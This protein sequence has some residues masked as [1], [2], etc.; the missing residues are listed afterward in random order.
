MEEENIKDPC[1]FWKSIRTSCKL[2]IKKGK[3]FANPPPPQI[4]KLVSIFHKNPLYVSKLKKKKNSSKKLKHS[5][6]LT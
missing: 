3:N 4:G 2:V 5:Y 1:L 6:Y